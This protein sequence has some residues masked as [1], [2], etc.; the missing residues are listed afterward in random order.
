MSLTTTFELRSNAASDEHRELHPAS[1]TVEVTVTDRD[2]LTVTHA[3]IGAGTRGTVDPEVL[4]LLCG[5]RD[6]LRE[7]IEI[8]LERDVLDAEPKRGAA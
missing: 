3:Y 1:T 4:A 6:A 8:A 2:S 5:G 7:A